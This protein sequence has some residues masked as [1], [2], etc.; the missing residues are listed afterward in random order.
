MAWNEPGKGKDSWGGGDRN[1]NNQGNGPPD[2][3][4]I[5]KRFRERFG[6]NGGSG[7]Q[8]GGNG[9]S[10]GAGVPSGLIAVVIA[11]LAGAWLVF[12]GLY[13]VQPGEKGV[14]LRFGEYVDTASPGW[15]WHLP[16]PIATVSKV[17]VQQVR[18]VSNRAVML[19]KDEN[20][21]DVEISA[22]YRISNA[23][24]YLFQLENPD[25][26]VQQV[27]RSAVREIVGTSNMN[28]VIQEGVQVNQLEDR[29]I[30]NVD[31]KEGSGQP[32]KK[33]GLKDIDRELVGQIKQ[34]QNEYPQI[35]D[36]SRA[37]LPTNVRKIMQF[38]LN[39]YDAG[40]QI[41]AVN[42]Q[43][44]QP[45]EP[46]QGA[47]QEAIK[48]REEEERLKNIARAYAREVVATAQGEK[49]QMIAEARAYKSRKVNRAEGQAARF[50]DLLTQYEQA[51]EVTRS[52]LY[53]ETMGEVLSGSHLVLDSGDGNSMT[54]LPLDKIIDKSG[55]KKPA[56]DNAP[57]ADSDNVGGDMPSS[58][59]SSS[60]SQNNGD[61]A[62]GNNGQSDTSNYESQALRSRSRNS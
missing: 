8:G 2:L 41:V 32:K 19:T 1:K 15:H 21:V 5:W 3:D 20:I 9:G 40:V 17:D 10:G 59:S 62:S 24:N 25:Q 37:K 30:N 60:G 12:G 39:K 31:L 48:A 51:P 47:F 61:S 4:Q 57:S 22:Q 54:Y 26:T 56:N 18:R 33:D 58:P 43:Y 6:G 27:L 28:Q 14:V 38:T 13:V 23:M 53:L 44:A 55:A 49:A 52:R 16:Y 11:I 50:S 46:V 35:T 34:K 29:A 45:P 42:V 7:N 36:R